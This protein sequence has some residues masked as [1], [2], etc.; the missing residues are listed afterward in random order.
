LA[1]TILAETQSVNA[2]PVAGL[3]DFSLPREVSLLPQTW[4]S[5]IAIALLLVAA[6]AAIWHFARQRRLNR[7]RRE[8]LAELSQLARPDGRAD[9]PSR[10]SVLVR[11]TAL[12]AFPRG[13]VVPL[14][15][16]AWLSF[17]DRSYGGQE[18]S[19]G[20]G[21]L[22]A[23]GPY[24]EIAPGDAELNSLTELVRRWIKVHHA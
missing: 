20:V 6:A 17:L 3:V 1:E 12:A 15:G 4:P 14:T 11:R 23:N 8:A 2:D 19:Q 9:L 24:Q 21:R 5:R 16:S 7:Y 10:L 22:L 13:E 18:F